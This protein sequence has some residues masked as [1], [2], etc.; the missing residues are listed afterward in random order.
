MVTVDHE[1]EMQKPLAELSESFGVEQIINISCVL[2]IPLPPVCV[3]AASLDQ[4]TE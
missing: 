4:E 2:T 3:V 1:Q